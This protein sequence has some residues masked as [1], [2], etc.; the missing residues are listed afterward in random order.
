MNEVSSADSSALAGSELALLFNLSPLLIRFSPA[1]FSSHEGM[2]AM[3][4]MTVLFGLT[5]FALPTPFLRLLSVGIG[6]SSA[7]LAICADLARIKG[8]KEAY[9][10][11]KSE[12]VP[13]QIP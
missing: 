5:A 2:I 1:F 8:T 7:W 10:Q 12:F 13:P 11:T 6:M 3:R 9:S 4:G